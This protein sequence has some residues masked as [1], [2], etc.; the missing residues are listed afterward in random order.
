MQNVILS[1]IINLMMAGLLLATM[2]Y[3]LRL[4]ARIKVLQD[5]KSELARIIREFDESTTRATESIVE[6]HKATT[7]ISENI[8]H[9]IDKANFLANDLEYMIEK[10]NKLAGKVDPAPVRPARA[11]EPAPVPA[12]RESA[13]PLGAQ[14]AEI[15]DITPG[16]GAAAKRTP[17]MRSRAEQELMSML[18][19]KPTDQAG[20]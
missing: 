18:G 19:K 6:I 2:V 12:A 9:K 16:G 17:R 11:P 3:C 4:N 14:R 5:S 10:G 13:S 1:L 20:G 15:Q 8:Q 7:R